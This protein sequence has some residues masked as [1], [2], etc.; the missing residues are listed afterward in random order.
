MLLH[1]IA[2]ALFVGAIAVPLC[3]LRFVYGLVRKPASR[4]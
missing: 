2:V 1:V 3:L 4:R